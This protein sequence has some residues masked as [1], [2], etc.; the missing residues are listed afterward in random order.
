MAILDQGLRDETAL[1][2]VKKISWKKAGAAVEG[3]DG[4]LVSCSRQTALYGFPAFC[5]PWKRDGSKERCSMRSDD[6]AD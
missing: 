3:R 6:G 2:L 1:S 5:E 4:A